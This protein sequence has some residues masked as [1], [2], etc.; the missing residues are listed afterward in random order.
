M[1]KCNAFFIFIQKHFLEGNYFAIL[2]NKDVYYG[3]SYEST[4]FHAD[5]ENVH[6]IF[7]LSEKQ[8]FYLKKMSSQYFF[9][10]IQG[11]RATHG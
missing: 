7:L 8:Y 6:N 5:I 1:V 10:K 11:P 3:M 4:S 9:N 2:N